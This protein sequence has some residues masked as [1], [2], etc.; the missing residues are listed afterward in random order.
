MSN[1][2]YHSLVLLLKDG[3]VTNV[4][5]V[6]NSLALSTVPKNLLDIIY[7]GR[8]ETP[9][10]ALCHTGKDVKIMSPR[11]PVLLQIAKGVWG[12]SLT[13]RHG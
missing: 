10:L 8:C 11:L 2:E 4:N 6:D 9:T 3:L 1:K 7:I 12:Q 5:G 13:M